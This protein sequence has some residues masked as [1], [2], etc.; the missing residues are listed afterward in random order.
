MLQTLDVFHKHNHYF[1]LMQT[2]HAF[3]KLIQTSQ[4]FS[5]H[6]ELIM[7]KNIVDFDNA[8]YARPCLKSNLTAI[9]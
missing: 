7:A 5:M 3:S 2:L 1:C 4:S 8:L 9:L 6:I